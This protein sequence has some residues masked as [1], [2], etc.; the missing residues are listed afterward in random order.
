M[1]VNLQAHKSS[2]PCNQLLKPHGAYLSLYIIAG[3]WFLAIFH[4][5]KFTLF[6]WVR[7]AAAAACRSLRSLQVATPRVDSKFFFPW[8]MRGF[9]KTSESARVHI[10]V[11][12]LFQ[13]QYWKLVAPLFI[14]KKIRI[15][16]LCCRH[17][18]GM[19]T[20]WTFLKNSDMLMN[21]KVT[22]AASIIDMIRASYWKGWEVCMQSS[23]SI[24]FPNWVSHMEYPVMKGTA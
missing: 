5:K 22:T 1:T 4:C 7:S 16:K 17:H 9:M 13:M 24:F 6:L 21:Q 10:Q 2:P 23:S 8:P 19:Y 11:Q 12:F 14:V 3:K 20:V 15:T 18:A